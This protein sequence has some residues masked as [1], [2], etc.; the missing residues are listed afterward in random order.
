[1]AMYLEWS[2]IDLVLLVPS[3]LVF[4]LEYIIY[5]Y[6]NRNGIDQILLYLQ[7]LINIYPSPPIIR[8]LFPFLNPDRCAPGLLVLISVT[9]QTN[10]TRSQIPG[11]RISSEDTTKSFR[12]ISCRTRQYKDSTGQYSTYLALTVQ[13]LNS[14]DDLY[15]LDFAPFIPQFQCVTYLSRRRRADILLIS[16]I[17]CI[18]RPRHFWS[19]KFGSVAIKAVK[20]QNFT[21]DAVKSFLVHIRL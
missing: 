13:G 6:F 9:F 4:V 1:M 11:Q 5:T 18:Y 10:L 3:Q 14:N 12:I 8:T 15:S 2:N 16:S 7:A 19:H 21:T 20:H 17:Q